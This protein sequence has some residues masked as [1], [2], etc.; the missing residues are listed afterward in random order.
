MSAPTKQWN[1]SG[2]RES[3]CTCHDETSPA[4]ACSWCGC[5]P[6]EGRDTKARETDRLAWIEYDAIATSLARRGEP[7]RIGTALPPLVSMEA[8]ALIEDDPEAFM[9][10]VRAIAY[11][12]AMERINGDTP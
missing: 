11:G 5:R 3:V 9:E 1:R 12:I 6:D 10:R 2:C 4:Y 8:V 7:C